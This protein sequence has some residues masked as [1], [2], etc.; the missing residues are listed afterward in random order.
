LKVIYSL[1]VSSIHVNLF[2]LKD[3]EKLT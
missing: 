3:K 2:D 1:E